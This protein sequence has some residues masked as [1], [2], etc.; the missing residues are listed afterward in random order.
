MQIAFEKFF[1][2]LED[3]S[4]DIPRD[5]RRDQIAENNFGSRPF[6]RTLVAETNRRIIG[7]VSFYPGFLNENPPIKTYH[8]P[9][10]FVTPEF[11][12]TA[13]IIL[14]NAVKELA[15]TEN[16]SR[17]VFSVYGRN[18]P[19][20]KLYEHAGAKYWAADADEHFMYFDV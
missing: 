8:F 14:L 4:Y 5:A 2:K 3:H 18:I 15:R 19:A 20:K 17:L 12:G 6:M 1:Q 10:L 16:I 11:R 13:T 9:Y 7:A